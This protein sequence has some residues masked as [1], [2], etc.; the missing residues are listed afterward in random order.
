[1]TQLDIEYIGDL[2][3]KVNH[4]PSGQTFYT[5]APIDNQ[6]KGESISPTDMIA[7]ALGACFSTISGIAA[8]THGIDIDGMKLSVFKEM[9]PA[10]DRKISRLTVN[11]ILPKKLSDKDFA[12]IKNIIKTCPVAKSIHPDIEVVSSIS[13][14]EGIE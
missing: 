10:P 7:A 1:M 11:I 12:I 2:R 4:V 14:A 13:Y 8:K 5:D 9:A 6:G 3:C